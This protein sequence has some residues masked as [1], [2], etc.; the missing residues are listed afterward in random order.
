M[1]TN[2]LHYNGTNGFLVTPF[3][4]FNQTD[5]AFDSLASG[6]TVTSANGGTSG[7]FNQTNFGS[8]Q[9]AELWFVVGDTGFTPSAGGNLTGWW[10]KSF[11]G[12]STFEDTDSN[13]A[14]PRP[15]DFIIPFKAAAYSASD[16]VFASGPVLLPYV[17][18]KVY[19]QNNSG[20]TLG[21][22]STTHAKLWCGP[23]ADQY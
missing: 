8:A 7:K 18:S 4:L 19:V 11:D 15:P 21:N 17:T 3:E 1:P 22:T 20:V 23:V 13:L 6:N 2:F 9:L 12:G 14:L 5:A 16:V 10:L